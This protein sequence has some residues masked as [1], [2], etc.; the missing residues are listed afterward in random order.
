MCA[1]FYG[2]NPFTRLTA[3]YQYVSL[4]VEL[5]RDAANRLSHDMGM[6]SGI[7]LLYRVIAASLLSRASRLLLE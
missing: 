5:G 6:D 7:L 4:N 1:N 3:S 2:V